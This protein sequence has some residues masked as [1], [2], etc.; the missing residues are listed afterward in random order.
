MAYKG[1]PK[2]GNFTWEENSFL[3]KVPKSVNETMTRIINK[4]NIIG[5]TKL[6]CFITDFYYTL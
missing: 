1:S 2:F 4:T 6:S 3:G 5:S